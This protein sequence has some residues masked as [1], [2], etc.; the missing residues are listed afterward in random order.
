MRGGEPER[1]LNAGYT[2][3]AF[4]DGTCEYLEAPACIRYTYTYI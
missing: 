4:Y 2:M 3:E 1:R